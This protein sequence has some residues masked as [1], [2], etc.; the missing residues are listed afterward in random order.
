[1]A[2]KQREEPEWHNR[3]HLSGFLRCEFQNNPAADRNYKGKYLEISGV[4]ERSGLDGDNIP[5]VIL[6]AGD[7]RAA[8]KIECFFDLADDDDEAE[9][10]RLRRGQAVT[11]RGDYN[12][13][14]SNLKVRDAV[15]VR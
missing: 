12:G 3:K 7:D 10:L 11:V 6:H 5:F 4:V 9:I 13:L 15:L 1:M 14:V 8:L 2:R